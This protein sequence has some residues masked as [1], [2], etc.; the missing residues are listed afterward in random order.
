MAG[1]VRAS[2]QPRNLSFARV[3][4]GGIDRKISYGGEVGHRFLTQE[5]RVPAIA[6]TSR[7]AHPAP[8]SEWELEPIHPLVLRM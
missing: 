1:G 7:A 3:R 4:D 6:D 5:G 8:A 2:G